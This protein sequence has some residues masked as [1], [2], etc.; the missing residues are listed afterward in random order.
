MAKRSVYQVSAVILRRVGSA[1][2]RSAD[3][4][5]RWPSD[6][7]RMASSADIDRSIGDG[8]V[9]ETVGARNAVNGLL[10]AGCVLEHGIL[11]AKTADHSDALQTSTCVSLL[12]RSVVAVKYLGSVESLECYVADVTA[13][14]DDGR[15]DIGATS[16]EHASVAATK[17]GLAADHI[18][19]IAQP[20]T[21]S[22]H[23][24]KDRTA[25]QRQDLHHY[26]NERVG[27]DVLVPE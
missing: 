23:C 11:G 27:V 14:H 1:T 21:Q 5:G 24:Q 18:T 10:Q 8:D 17:T 4:V 2:Y 12:P 22:L 16:L 9:L 20:A 6:S 25:I 26:A 15:A 3:G 19:D 13:L 7:C